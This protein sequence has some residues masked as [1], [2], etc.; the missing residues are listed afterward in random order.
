VEVKVLM[1]CEYCGEEIGLLAVRYTWLDKK[2]K[3]AMHDKCYEIYTK[4]NPEKIEQPIEEKQV[5][6]EETKPLEKM[7]LSKILGIIILLITIPAAIY[8]FY[9]LF[10]F[11][12]ALSFFSIFAILLYLLC[13]FL[14]IELIRVKKKGGYYIFLLVVG[15]LFLVMI[16]IS[17]LASIYVYLATNW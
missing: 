12:N 1:K 13:I 9:I 7:I 15:I 3:R 6:K 4:E 14:G 11:E 17:M 5:Q 8:S 16:V 2:N 10:L